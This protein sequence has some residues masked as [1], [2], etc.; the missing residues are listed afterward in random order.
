MNIHDALL[1]EHSKAQAENIAQYVISQPQKLDELMACFFD[2]D[3]RICQRA[4]WPVCKLGIQTPQ[5]LERFIPS[6]IKNLEVPKHDAVIRNT[7]RVWSEMHIAEEFEG[8]IF[9]LCFNYLCNRK[10]A[11]AVRAF[12]ITVATKIA[13]KYPELTKDLIL[14]L[15]NQMLYETKAAVVV[16]LKRHIK[17]LEK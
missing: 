12:S 6:M 16:R 3:L 7:V 17:Q 10:M 8:S 5:L 14:E 15:K 13:L 1:R 9:D 2:P 4:S 11:V